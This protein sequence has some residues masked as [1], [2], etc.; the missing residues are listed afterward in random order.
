VIATGARPNNTVYQHFKGKVS[1]L[2]LIGDG[3]EVRKSTD[4]ISEGFEVGCRI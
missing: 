3:K 2:Y 4:A 1:E